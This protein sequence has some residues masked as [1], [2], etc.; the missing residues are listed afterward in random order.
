MPPGRFGRLRHLKRNGRPLAGF[1]FK[2]L[3]ILRIVNSYNLSRRTLIGA[4]MAAGSFAAMPA[5]AE[6]QI[7]IV[8]VG[9]NQ[10]PLAMK[11]FAGSH[12]A[13]TDVFAVLK[14]DLARCGAFR[15]VNPIAE[16]GTESLIKPE[17]LLDWG[18]V[19]ANALVTGSVERMN[20]TTWDLRCYLHDVVTGEVLE[21]LSFSAGKNGLRMAAHRMAD[22]IYSRL[23]GEG[24][25]FASRLLYVSQLARNHYELI[26]SDCDGANPRV[27][28]N[29]SEPII[30]PVWAP[31]GR[32]IA[33]VS[34]EELA[35]MKKA[36]VYVQDLASGARQAIAT[37]RGNNS[38]PAF[39]PDGTKLAVALSRDG[40]TQI[41]LINANGTGLRRFTHSY[42][43]DTEPVFSK[44]GKYIYF[45][46]DRGGAPQ[47]Y[48]QGLETG[49]RAERVTFGSS[50]AISPDISPDGRYLT[51]VSRA[52]GRFRI[53]M[54]EL[55]TGHTTLVTTTDKDESPSFAPNGRFLVY[56][57]EENGRGV[58]GTASTD[59]RLATRLTGKGDIREPSW[60]PVI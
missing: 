27:A 22:K 58:L 39:S 23:T 41:Y 49:S 2:D 29:S 60:G 1:P 18:R 13:P 55:A 46:S 8:G 30:S 17:N 51:F 4:G 21:T 45:V 14:D 7:S 33:Y 43:I 6:L 36:V 24:A 53:A 15:F 26:V 28:L 5:L 3:E 59:G 31:D 34:F 42:G 47:I 48:R 38:A 57:T 54:M 10:M 37:F 19:G 12:D 35:G 20:D 52:E 44:D 32:R 11:P 9:A 16:T 50:Y 56:A 25:M 40:L